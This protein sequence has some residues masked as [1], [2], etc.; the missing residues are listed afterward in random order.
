MSK[1]VCS[2]MV[3]PSNVITGSTS[4]IN[5]GHPA[6]FPAYLPQF[7]IKLTTDIGDTVLDPFMGSGTTGLVCEGLDVNFIGIELDRDYFDI[8]KNRILKGEN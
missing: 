1:R 7:F 3:R 5:I 6:V 4:N 2:D 8:A